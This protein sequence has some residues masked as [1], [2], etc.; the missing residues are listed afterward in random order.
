MKGEVDPI[1]NDESTGYKDV[2]R[3]WRD[4]IIYCFRTGAL[5][6]NLMDGNQVAF[7]LPQQAG[8]RRFYMNE[9]RNPQIH[10]RVDRA[11][12]GDDIFNTSKYDFVARFEKKVD[13]NWIPVDAVIRVDT[14]KSGND[15]YY[16]DE[17]GNVDYTI[18]VNSLGE[19]TERQV[20]PFVQKDNQG[21]YYNYD[22]KKYRYYGVNYER[23][24]RFAT[25][26]GG[27]MESAAE[28][29]GASKASYYYPLKWIPT[30]FNSIEKAIEYYESM[31]K[32][33]STSLKN[34]LSSVSSALTSLKNELKDAM[35]HE[36]YPRPKDVDIR[37]VYKDAYSIYRDGGSQN[38]ID[39]YEK[40]LKTMQDTKEN[41]ERC[42]NDGEV[43]ETYWSGGKQYVRTY[44]NR[45]FLSLTAYKSYIDYYDGEIRKAW[46]ALDFSYSNRTVELNKLKALYLE[47]DVPYS[48]IKADYEN[49]VKVEPVLTKAK[50]ERETQKTTMANVRDAKYT[51]SQKRSYLSNLN[52]AKTDK[53]E[54]W[55]KEAGDLYPEYW[56][57][58]EVSQIADAF[59]D[60]VAELTKYVRFLQNSETVK[61]KA[62]ELEALLKSVNNY[63]DKIPEASRKYSDVKASF[64]NPAIRAFA[65]AKDATN[66]GSEFERAKTAFNAIE[67]TIF[68]SETLA[69]GFANEQKSASN[70]ALRLAESAASAAIAANDATVA[71]RKKTSSYNDNARKVNALKDA[72]EQAYAKAYDLANEV[73]D[74]SASVK[75]NTA[76]H[77]G[78]LNK[79]WGA[80]RMRQIVA[81][82]DSNAQK[83][84]RA[85]KKAIAYAN[86]DQLLVYSNKVDTEFAAM[87]NRL[88]L[89]IREIERT[90]SQLDKMNRRELDKVMNDMISHEYNMKKSLETI[91]ESV[92]TSK[93]INDEHSTYYVMVETL[94]AAEKY[95]D[96]ATYLKQGVNSDTKYF[97]NASNTLS[98]YTSNMKNT[99]SK[100]ATSM[101][102]K[103]TI[104]FRRSSMDAANKYVNS[105]NKLTSAV[106]SRLSTMNTSKTSKP[107][108]IALDSRYSRSSTSAKMESSTS[109]TSMLKNATAAKTNTTTA[110]TNDT[111]AK[112]NT[113]P[114][115]TNTTTVNSHSSTVKTNT[116][117]SSK[118][119]NFNNATNSKTTKQTGKVTPRRPGTMPGVAE[120]FE[121]MASDAPEAPE[122]PETPDGPAGAAV[123]SKVAGMMNA[124]LPMP[125]PK[126]AV[127]AESV[128]SSASAML[129]GKASASAEA[130]PDVPTVSGVS[131]PP[132]NDPYSSATSVLTKAYSNAGKA[133]TVYSTTSGATTHI[134][135][136]SLA[137]S[138][139]M[140]IPVQ[141]NNSSNQFQYLSFSNLDM[142]KSIGGK[143]GDY[144]Y[145][146]IISQVDK[147]K[148]QNAQLQSKKVTETSEEHAKLDASN[149]SYLSGTG[150]DGT[151]GNGDTYN[152]Q[153]YMANY[154]KE[155]EKQ[156]LQK[157]ESVDSLTKLQKQK[158]S[159]S[160]FA[161]EIYEWKLVFNP[162]LVVT[163]F[164]T[165]VA[166]NMKENGKSTSPG[167]SE[168]DSELE[169]LRATGFEYYNSSYSPSNLARYSDSYLM[170]LTSKDYVLKDPYVWL[171]YMG[172]FALF[173]G[174][175]VDK[176]S[177]YWDADWNSPR[178]L[179]RYATG[180][181]SIWLGSCVA[182]YVKHVDGVAQTSYSILY[183]N[184][185]LYLKDNFTIDSYYSASDLISTIAM[186]MRVPSRDECRAT[187]ITNGYMEN[188]KHVTW[189]YTPVEQ[190][191]QVLEYMYDMS[192]DI[193]RS[194]N[195]LYGKSKGSIKTQVDLWKSNNTMLGSTYGGG[196]RCPAYQV[197]FVYQSKWLND[198]D[199]GY[200]EYLKYFSGYSS[201]RYN[202]YAD[203][204][205]LSIRNYTKASGRSD[206][207]FNYN[208]YC[209]NMKSVTQEYY[210]CNAYNI[211]TQQYVLLS[212]TEDSYSKTMTWKDP[213]KGYDSKYTWPV[214]VQPIWK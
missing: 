180:T 150:K 211:K 22:G 84:M 41:M 147:V 13:G 190:I 19:I 188:N 60:S 193:Q 146:V 5:P 136:K 210:R 27:I 20:D 95:S 138:T 57:S 141:F 174:R 98:G 85:Y 2:N 61:N 32:S 175:Q 93:G 96:A 59:A 114:A 155:M 38:M 167:Y 130:A 50:A 7:T 100:T 44:E 54:K 21:Y 31:I 29:V 184:G 127:P 102:E 18:K 30:G 25:T 63:M 37:Y 83:A 160:N 74:I 88:D 111:P 156:G 72:E 171:A 16:V 49:A 121:L 80:D 86:S 65:A 117:T 207:R 119:S 14:Y 185:G 137:N 106:E 168:L 40:N 46:N 166:G 26:L 183:T 64:Y 144:E 82:C 101:E 176:K 187:N 3:P 48:K 89:M 120:A 77:T 172:G 189:L 164:A 15:Y 213:L 17:N 52:T 124:S 157:N 9:L 23:I 53:F 161:N 10:L 135:A 28:I 182:P 66:H 68:S 75:K 204:V 139:L 158:I 198:N 105:I 87:K 154:Y 108:T 132:A 123:V 133:T 107:G 140:T 118:S 143:Y 71:E 195:L 12:A 112:T 39:R 55:R 43:R 186:G 197:G 145:R 1:F 11:Q 73:G 153:A 51:I 169:G 208:W 173:N 81:D 163:D 70:A 142:V 122:T 178:A 24:Q 6:N 199:K 110:K 131:A 203:Q 79:T 151:E 91:K 209:N 90:L 103:S 115:K 212:G 165:W 148:F 4:S 128:I 116:T 34:Q 205:A 36:Y 76:R 97:A 78:E 109:L 8:G 42:L 99:L 202:K 152:L 33:E 206:F 58:K 201:T 149:Q 159:Y 194:Y 196:I 162:Y 134:D 181:A 192:L 92:E 62:D 45:H 47:L 35:A 177:A 94:N 126:P 125:K 170:D 129:N 179:A 113:T 200:G 191:K 104:S 69:L 56:M 67:S 214:T